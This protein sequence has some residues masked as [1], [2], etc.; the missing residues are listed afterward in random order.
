MVASLTGL[1][2][3]CW[4]VTEGHAQFEQAEIQGMREGTKVRG[5]QGER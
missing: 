1:D 5:K 2:K 3:A 4:L